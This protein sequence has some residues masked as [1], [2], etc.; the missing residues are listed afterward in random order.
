MTDNP[1]IG[2]DKA[3]SWEKGYQYGRNIPT[4]ATRGHRSFF[5]RTGSLLG[6]REPSLG[7]RV[8]RSRA[9]K[10]QRPPLRSS[11]PR[12]TSPVRKTSAKPS[13]T[14]PYR[15]PTSMLGSAPLMSDR[16]EPHG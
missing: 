15:P 9:R 13:R 7:E 16:S 14:H 6:R 11:Q 1:Y 5:Q 3:E 10:L 4:R 2:T 8:H 12:P